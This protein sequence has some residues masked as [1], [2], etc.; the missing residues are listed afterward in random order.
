MEFARRK[1]GLYFAKEIMINKQKTI[2][3]P[4]AAPA[5]FRNLLFFKGSVFDKIQELLKVRNDLRFVFIVQKKRDY[6]KHYDFFKPYLSDKCLYEGVDV[7]IAKNFIQKIFYFWYSYLVYTGTTRILA[8]MGT[9]PDEPPAGGRWYLAFFKN[10]IANTF[11]RL[12]YIK[13]RVVPFLF[14]LIFKDR[15]F[16]ELFN[17]YK[18]DLI[19]ATHL[20]G[21]FDA[22][23]LS[24][25]RRREVSSIG[26]PAGWDHLDKYFLPFQVDKLLVPSE[27]V[28]DMAIKFQAYKPENISLTGY[29]HFDFI[30]DK[31]L[32]LPREELMKSLNFPVNAKLIIYISG[33]AYCPDEPDI[34]ET[35]LK[36]MDEGK[37]GSEDVRLVIRP[38]AGGRTKD[39]EIEDQK[40][41]RFENHPRV[42]F[43]KREFWGDIEK[44]AYFVN[45]LHHADLVISIYS[46]A[47]L[48]AAIHDRPLMALSFDGYKVQPFEKS[49]RRF[50]EFDHFKAVLDTGA[51]KIA[52]SFE[53]L[54]SF[55]Q[56]YLNNP[57]LDAEGREVLRQEVCNNPD[58]KSSERIFK[59]LVSEADRC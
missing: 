5:V 32:L 15:P 2:F 27:Q 25:G 7:S 52:R 19:F 28:K 18:P 43:Y 22:L 56:G 31:S 46:T 16:Y 26:M 24:E 17:K 57:S 49:I 42:V 35:M 37:F 48:E 23:L 9:R 47:I 41:N 53:D 51:V 40:F 30:V 39:R 20:Y 11:G 21:W 44:S 50:E 8:T 33:S 55:T 36:W 29:T 14:Q 59:A 13:R 54:F 58:G 38:Y 3:I 45:L 1:Y 4:V 10:L 12:I 6:D 34:I